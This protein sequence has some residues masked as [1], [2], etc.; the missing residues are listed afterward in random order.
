MSDLE[1]LETK[2]LK[3]L[4]SKSMAVGLYQWI[5]TKRTCLTTEI[6]KILEALGT[7]S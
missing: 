1:A 5:V 7:D 4:I 2:P 6:T 3:N